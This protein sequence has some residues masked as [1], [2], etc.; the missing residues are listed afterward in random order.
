[1]KL[2]NHGFILKSLMHYCLLTGFLY[3]ATAFQYLYAELEEQDVNNNPTAEFESSAL[4]GGAQNINLAQ[5]A[6]GNP[7]QLGKYEVNVYINNKFHGKKE[8]EFKQHGDVVEHCFEYA[9][10]QELSIDLQHVKIKDQQQCLLLSQW[11][12]AASSSM[13][14]NNL[15]Y[16]LQIP[17]A[18]LKRTSRGYIPYPLWDRGINAAYV[19]YNFNTLESRIHHH[20]DNHSYLSLNTG[21]NLA[22]WQFRHNAVARLQR[23][24]QLDYEGLNTYV[25]RA[26]PQINSV[27]TLGE[28]YSPGEHFNSFAFTGLQLNSEDR[29]LPET[30]TGYAPVIRGIAYSNAVVEVR[31][32]KQLIYQTTVNPGAF[33][34]TDLYPTG[35]GGDLQ[36]T[37]READGQ[38]QQF[39]VPYASVSQLLRPNHS[40]YA[41]TI[42]RV[43][44]EHLLEKDFFSQL[45]Y[46]RGLNNIVTAY[47]GAIYSEHYQALQL[48]SAF[49]TVLG[50]LAFDVTHARTESLQAAQNNLEGQS[51]RL[52]FSK[53]LAGTGSLF[54]IAAS[55]Y[56]TRNYYHFSDANLY[57]DMQRR[58][59]EMLDSSRQKNQL[60]LS[61][62]QE[63]GKQAGSFYLSG[64]WN[65]Y[66]GDSRAQKDW[67]IGYNNQ[68]KQLNYSLVMQKTTDVQGNRDEQY[69]LMLSLPLQTKQ[70]NSLNLMHVISDDGNN[71]SVSGLFGADQ[72]YNYNV[73]VND[74]GYTQYSSDARLQYRSP[75]L[76]SAVF[77]SAG[78]N[79]HQYGLN[80][81]GTVLAH[82]QGISF[83]PEMGQTMVLVQAD[84]AKGAQI[85]NTTALKIDRWGFAVIPYVSAYRMNEISID[86]KDIHD[87]VELLSSL[88]ELVPYAGAIAKVEFKTQKGFLLSIKS[89]QASGAPLPFAAQVFDQN[90]QV[91]GVVAQGSQLILR[92][93]LHQG[94]LRVKWGDAATEQCQI[95]YQL[96]AN[97]PHTGYQKI[98]VPCQ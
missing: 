20:Q 33:A 79:Y 90:N 91:V 32:N 89:K 19:S 60:Q 52:S 94:T 31:Q 81:T 21:L 23:G 4:V 57:Q 62:N 73:S 25:Q 64:S 65:E 51:Y 86:S 2:N 84:A 17:Q 72:A 49:S 68:Y 9:E 40:R 95:H 85:K 28:S 10:L 58:G 14:S 92:S 44:N 35:S 13:D 75:Y 63:L 54:N 46:Q 80:L 1:M 98:E 29:M 47:G 78:Q 12:S 3:T 55:H 15:R 27:L 41:L 42:G 67:Q 97:T 74:I 5:F 48:G 71:S 45:S 26:F 39:N 30:A 18:Y 56:A 7:V 8:L 96:D 87:Q 11:I 53:A 93:A 37:V 22:G 76:S 66:W 69:M 24:E 50:A 16:D 61:W 70:R 88:K 83:S 77:A 43:R 6:K 38:T 34:I 36:V 59:N 82:R